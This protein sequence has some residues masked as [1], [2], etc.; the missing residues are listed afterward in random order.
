MRLVDLPTPG[1]DII[2]GY[3][4]ADKLSRERAVDLLAQLG[5]KNPSQ[6][7]YDCLCNECWGEVYEY[8]MKVDRVTEALVHQFDTFRD[9][10]KQAG[11]NLLEVS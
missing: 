9:L 2:Q 6:E 8:R 1:Y 5:V 3:S 4:L 11:I 10:F 7:K